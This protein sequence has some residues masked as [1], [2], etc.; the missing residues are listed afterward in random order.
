VTAAATAPSCSIRRRTALETAGGIAQARHLLGETPFIAVSGDI[1]CPHF[2]Y[3]ELLT[4]LEDEDPG[5]IRC[6]GQARHGL[7]VSGQESALPSRGRLSLNNFSI[8]NEGSQ[9][10]LRQHRRV[11]PADVR[12]HRPGSTPNSARCC[13]STPHGPVGGDVYRGVAQ[14]RHH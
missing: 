3:A 6:R 14:R 9:A 8:A 1:W 13:A 5:A 2:D 7:A 11:P 4:V 12:W 10:D